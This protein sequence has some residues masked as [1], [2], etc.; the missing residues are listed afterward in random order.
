M[1][2][3]FRLRN[4]HGLPIKS[5]FV[6]KVE[7]GYPLMSDLS[8][9]YKSLKHICSRLLIIAYF[10]TNFSSACATPSFSLDNVISFAMPFRR[11]VPFSITTPRPAA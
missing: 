2:R 11:S 5:G 3:L 6:W 8:T 7:H 1:P 4:G 9:A 10:K